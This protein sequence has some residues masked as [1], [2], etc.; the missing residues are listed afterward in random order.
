MA[1]SW[2][3]MWLLF[4]ILALGAIFK[5]WGPP[6]DPGVSFMF[7]KTTLRK[8]GFW[9]YVFEHWNWIIVSIA[10]IIPPHP[11]FK[12]TDRLFIVLMVLDFVH[13]RLFFRDEINSKLFW[14]VLKV[15]TFGTSLLYDRF[16][17]M[18]ATRRYTKGD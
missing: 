14:N 18:H 1:L 17:M 2:F 16:K 13:F 10:L 7:S 5:I 15:T 9:Y 12:F 6:E 8:D 3:R 11:A 4:T